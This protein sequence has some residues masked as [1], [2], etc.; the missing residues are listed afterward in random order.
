[1]SSAAPKTFVGLPV[2]GA[3]RRYQVLRPIHERRLTSDLALLIHPQSGAWV[4][5]KAQTVNATRRFLDACESSGFDE[6]GLIRSPLFERLCNCGLI[7]E[8]RSGVACEGGCSGSSGLLNTLIL[9]LV[10]YCDLACR[11][12]Y[13]Y[14]A[15]MY[16]RRMSDDIARRA[17][18]DSLARSGPA[19]RIL[20][21][22]GEPLLAIDQIRS[23]VPFALEAARAA[24]REVR[25]TVQTNGRHFLREK[26]SIFCSST[27]SRSAFLWTV[28]PMSTIGT[29]SITRGVGTLP[30]S[31]P[32][33]DRILGCWPRSAC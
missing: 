13:D 24:G 23:L 28:L 1:M 8:Q 2:L 3:P 9:K 14:R 17:I 5:V 6:E 4:M 29:V 18:V 32:R 20:F 19:L 16:S 30:K 10:G 12:C 33:C 22:G 21:H 27:G 31:K 11:Y 7:R 26:P 15:E 25:F